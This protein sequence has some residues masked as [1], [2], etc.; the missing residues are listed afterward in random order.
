MWKFVFQSDKNPVS[1]D[2]LI[3]LDGVYSFIEAWS[4]K[5]LRFLFSHEVCKDPFR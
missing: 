2:E 1:H 5:S 4:T 3:V